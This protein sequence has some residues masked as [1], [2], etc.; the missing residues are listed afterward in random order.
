ML[1]ACC[2]RGFSLNPSLGTNRYA[3]T[4]WTLRD[5]FFKGAIQTIAQK[6]DG[7]LWLGTEFGLVRFDGVRSAPWTPPAY[8]DLPATVF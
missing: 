3:H 1:P 5:G 4:A 7:Y 2:P 8:A 6:P